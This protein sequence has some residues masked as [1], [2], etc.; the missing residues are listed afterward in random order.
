MAKAFD[1]VNHEILLKKLKNL[2]F[3]GNLLKLVQNYL[4][5]RKQRTTANG[6]VSSEE[7]ISCGIPQGSTVRLLMYII[8][9]NDIISSIK[10]CKYYMYADDT[11]I[12]TTGTLPGC[13]VRLTNDLSTFK[14]WCNLNK[15]TLNIKKMKYT[16]F[17]LRSHTKHFREHVLYIDN[18]K[19]DRVHTYKYLG[20]TLDANLTYSKHLETDIKSISDKALLL[21]K[22]RKYILQEV[23][24]RIYK[25]MILPVMEYGDILYDG[26]SKKL[27]G[28]IQ[29]LQNRCLRTCLLPDQHIP[30]IRLYEI[31]SIANLNMRRRIHLQLNMYKQKNN[32]SIVNTR[33]IATRIH[34]ATLFTTIK[35]N[36]EK[37]KMNVLYKGAMAWN[38]LSVN[39]RKSQT[40]ISLKDVLNEKL[41]SEIVPTREQQG[42]MTQIFI[43][44]CIIIRKAFNI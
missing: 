20:I 32:L 9:V 34:D 16:I 44:S 17:G 12:Y 26:A 10:A 37:Y 3:T 14:Q 43:C 18:I 19:I 29:V 7:N 13:T 8:Y 38:S 11:A 30:T 5:N 15:L 24:L 31:C 21:A 2:G 42:I 1:T 33:K 35:P 22:M 27:T 39:I 4:Q 28:K 41:I 6:C 40:Y 23:A 25:T 36:S